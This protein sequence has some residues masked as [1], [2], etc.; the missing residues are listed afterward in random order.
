[1]CRSTVLLSLGYVRTADDDLIKQ[2]RSL[3]DKVWQGNQRIL[4]VACEKAHDRGHIVV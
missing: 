3:D 1:M 4:N 2:E